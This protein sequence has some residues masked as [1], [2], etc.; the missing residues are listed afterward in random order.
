MA[1]ICNGM[2]AFGCMRPFCST[3]LNFIEY[4]F[5]A[6]RLSALSH[7]PVLYVMTHDSVGLGEDGPTHQPIEAIPLLRSTP[8]LEVWRPADGNEVN[9]AYIKALQNT[10]TPSV[11]CLSRQAMPHIPTSSFE[12]AAMGAY[13]AVHE[14]EA[15][16]VD[17]NP[18]CLSV[19]LR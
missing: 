17:P 13:V 8:H 3:F 4:C 7:F 9:A 14:T 2:F 11:L 19:C 10:R 15:V 6:V 12:H 18:D 5:P 1:A 16:Q